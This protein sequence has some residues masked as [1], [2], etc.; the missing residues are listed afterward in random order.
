MKLI[1]LI[2]L[3]I[4]DSIY[5]IKTLHIP[6]KM[7]L[8]HSVLSASVVVITLL[9][10]MK[11]ISFSSPFLPAFLLFIMFFAYLIKKKALGEG[12]LI[13]LIL[14]IPVLGAYGFLLTLSLSFFLSGIVSG[15]LLITKRKNGKS[16]IP[17]VPFLASGTI[18][19]SFIIH[20]GGVV[21]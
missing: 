6:L 16:R 21:I 18:L 8:L 19:Y 2:V 4:I 20:L 15:I 11:K 1:L 14:M 10:N 13:L 9:S 12:D 7:I 3:L 5:D 17:F